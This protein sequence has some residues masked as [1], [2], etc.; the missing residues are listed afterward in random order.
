MSAGLATL[1]VLGRGGIYEQIEKKTA[2]PVHGTAGSRSIG[3]RSRNAKQDSFTWMRVFY[4]R[5]GY[6]P[7]K[8][9]EIRYRGLRM[10]FR[11]MLKRGVYFA[12]S[13]FEAFFVSAAHEREDLD[14]TIQAAY[15]A[16]RSSGKNCASGVKH[17][18]GLTEKGLYGSTP[19]TFARKYDEKRRQKNT[20]AGR[21][22][23][24]YRFSGG[25][26][27]F[28]R[29]FDRGFPGSKFGT[30]PYLTIIFLIV[31]IAAGGLNYYRFAKQQQEEDK[32]RKK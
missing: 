23:Q 13:Q 22:G 19:G 5:T 25:L 27:A 12:P 18:K 30:F 17:E 21:N 31:G 20:H 6:G 3:R 10:F 29:D 2:Y 9:G 7:G 28:Y 16:L 11:E 8:R 15:E 14:L 26:C 4:R 24:H 1:N 32:D